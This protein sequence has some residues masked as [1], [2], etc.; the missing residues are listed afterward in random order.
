VG[1]GGSVPC[2]RR[3]VPVRQNEWG[4]WGLLPKLDGLHGETLIPFP[5]FSLEMKPLFDAQQISIPSLP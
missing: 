5:A 2:S 4:I 3:W 1:V